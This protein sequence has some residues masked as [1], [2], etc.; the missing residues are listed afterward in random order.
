MQDRAEFRLFHIFAKQMRFVRQFQC[1]FFQSCLPCP[2]REQRHHVFHH[3]SN[4]RR[5]GKD[6]LGPTPQIQLL[7]VN[8]RPFIPQLQLQCRHRGVASHSPIQ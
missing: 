4:T 6:E 2:G 1:L 5:T 7:V 8:G 3:F